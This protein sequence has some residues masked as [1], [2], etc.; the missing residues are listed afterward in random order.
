MQSISLQAVPNQTLTILLATQLTKLRIY[1]LLD[2]NLYMDVEVNAEAVVTGVLCR[3]STVI[4]RDAYHGFIGDL[5][6]VDT[7][8]NNDPVYSGL[9]SRYQ[10]MYLSAS[11]VA[12]L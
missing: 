3:N 8:G 7:Q 9:G 4:V 10:L 11:D 12:A 1:T 6:F 5:S 2:G